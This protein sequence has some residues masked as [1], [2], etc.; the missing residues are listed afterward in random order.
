MTFF[1]LA[2]DIASSSALECLGD[3]SLKGCSSSFGLDVE[4]HHFG[5]L[6]PGS[7]PQI[8]LFQQPISEQLRHS[9]G[10]KAN[11]CRARQVPSLVGSRL[12]SQILLLAI[13]RSRQLWQP[14]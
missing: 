1:G 9:F 13:L 2:S 8:S 7:D 5:P 3:E 10:V 6:K 11:S 14:S 12:H 4:N